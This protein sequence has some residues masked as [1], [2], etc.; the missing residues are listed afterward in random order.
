VRI[1]QE[2]DLRRFPAIPLA[3]KQFER[4]CLGRTATERVNAR[5]NSSGASATATAPAR[6]AS[7]PSSAP[8]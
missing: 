8:S 6:R 7:T 4:L 3:T 2:L 5:S 1:K